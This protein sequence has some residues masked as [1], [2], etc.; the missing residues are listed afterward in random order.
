MSVDPGEAEAAGRPSERRKEPQ[1]GIQTADHDPPWAQNRV[2]G[3]PC[4]QP[5]TRV[6][7]ASQPGGQGSKRAEHFAAACFVGRLVIGIAP[8]LEKSDTARLGEAV[9]A[10][11]EAPKES[12][13][14]RVPLD[15]AMTQR[16]I[17]KALQ[18][19]GYARFY[20]GDSAAAALDLQEAV[21]G[22]DAYPILW[23]YLARA[24]AGRQDEKR[25]LEQGAAGP[26]FGRYRR[27]SGHRT[28]PADQA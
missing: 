18:T 21:A 5:G 16:S 23:L 15:W 20:Q 1:A 3:V 2:Q 26:L 6:P 13:R 12:T 11:R 19:L 28:S 25:D 7:F 22:T 27:H 4:L 17:G 9:A 14:E 24:R 10:Y 8:L